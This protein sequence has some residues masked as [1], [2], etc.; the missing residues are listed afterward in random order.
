MVRGGKGRGRVSKKA[1]RGVRKTFSRGNCSE[2][3]QVLGEKQSQLPERTRRLIINMM[4]EQDCCALR[5]I[6]KNLLI[7]NL[8]MTQ[9]QKEKL[10]PHK[11]TI[12]AISKTKSAKKI[13]EHLNQDGGFLPLLFPLI[14]PLVLS[15]AAGAVGGAV[16]GA[17]LK[18]RR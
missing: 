10:R 8:P 13:R 14:K 7:G 3:F 16:K 17:V 1:R 18:K 5:E 9:Q 4:G 12:V 11:N 15:A 6:T 2:I